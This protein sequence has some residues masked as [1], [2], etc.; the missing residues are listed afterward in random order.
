MAHFEVDGDQLVLR[1]TPEEHLEGI[2][3]DLT[4]PRTSVVSAG[5]PRTS[6]PSSAVSGL[7]GPGFPVSSPWAPVEATSGRTSPPSTAR[8]VGWWSSSRVRPFERLIISAP[9]PEAEVARVIAQPARPPDGG[10]P[11]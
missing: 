5:S 7:R 3:R 4:V 8:A 1:L 10:A 11:L 9:D 2:H 6:G